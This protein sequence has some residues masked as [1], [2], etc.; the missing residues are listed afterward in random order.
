MPN[1]TESAA[2]ELFVSASAAH[3]VKR[4]AVILAQRGIPV[5]PLKGALLQKL[6]Y[7]SH[8][9]RPI[10]DV[11]LLV[12]EPDFVEAEGLLERS[13]F[14]VVSWEHGRWQVTLRDSAGPR[15]G[16]DLHRSLTRT[17][18]SNLSSQALFE[19]GS[20]DSAL[21]G[22]PLR[23]PSPLDLFAHLLLHAML[24]WMNLGRIPHPRDFELVASS[25]G[26]DPR[27]CARHLELTRLSVHAHVLFPR[28]GVTERGA[29]LERLGAEVA[30]T[31][32]RRARATAAMIAA[33]CRAFP[34]RHPARRLAGLALAPSIPVAVLSAI[35]DRLIRE[36]SGGFKPS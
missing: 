6:V 36:P 24:D 16:V 26:L 2:R 35:R 22:V 19:R 34:P 1:P 32:G 28:L 18:R 4:V 13:G 15:L 31:L 29:F 9:F 33:A 5:M 27:T 12:L 11:D 3:L 21:F 25:L 10:S 14:E 30:R 7:P 17:P 23:I 8:E 20:R